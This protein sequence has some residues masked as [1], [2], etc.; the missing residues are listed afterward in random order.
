MS[1]YNYRG[2]SSR[3]SVTDV[4]TDGSCLGNGQAGAKAG[5]GVFWGPD[6]PKWVLDFSFF[7]TIYILDDEKKNTQKNV[8]KFEGDMMLK[9]FLFLVFFFIL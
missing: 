3:N 5:I 7:Y 6:H 9:W 4:Y 8:M 1:G 2:N